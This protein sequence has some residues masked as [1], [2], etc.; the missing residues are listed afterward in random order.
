MINYIDNNVI[1]EIYIAN[2]D[3]NY[4]NLIDLYLNEDKD[5]IANQYKNSNIML[6]IS[7]YDKNY[8]NFVL[9][10]IYIN[11]QYK[12]VLIK[13]GSNYFTDFI[14][15][16]NQKYL[17]SFFIDRTFLAFNEYEIENDN[18]IIKSIEPLG[19][20]YRI[21][22]DYLNNSMSIKRLNKELDIYNKYNQINYTNRIIKIK[23]S[24]IDNKGFCLEDTTYDFSQ[25]SNITQPIRE[26]YNYKKKLFPYHEYNNVKNYIS[27]KDGANLEISEKTVKRF[28]R[29]SQSLD[30]HH[31]TFRT[32]LPGMGIY[33]INEEISQNKLVGNLDNMSSYSLPD[34][35]TYSPNY[36]YGKYKYTSKFIGYVLNTS[37]D[38]ID[39]LNSSYRINSENFSN[40]YSEETIYSEYFLYVLLDPSITTQAG[41]DEI[42]DELN[43]DHVN[44]VFDGTANKVYSEKEPLID[45]GITNEGNIY[46]V[47]HDGIDNS[48]NYILKTGQRSQGGNT[49]AVNPKNIYGTYGYV[50]TNSVT[51]LFDNETF[52]T[53]LG[54]EYYEEGSNYF[55]LYEDTDD[56]QYINYNTSQYYRNN[57]KY[58]DLLQ[59][60]LL[61]C[62]VIEK[63]VL[64]NTIEGY[65][66]LNRIACA[67]QVERPVFLK[68]NNVY[69][70]NEQ[71]YQK[72]FSNG[73][74]DLYYIEQLKNKCVSKYEPIFD[75]KSYRKL[76][77]KNF[78]IEN[79]INLN[80]RVNNEVEVNDHSLNINVNNDYNNISNNLDILENE[81]IYG[82]KPTYTFEENSDL[83]FID[84]NTNSFKYSQGNRFDIFNGSDKETSISQ[85]IGIK[86]IPVKILSGNILSKLNFNDENSYFDSFNEHLENVCL[87][88]IDYNQV[89]SFNNNISIGKY[90]TPIYSIVGNKSEMYNKS[91]I[92][93]NST[94]TDQIYNEIPEV[95]E[96]GNLYDSEEGVEKGYLICNYNVSILSQDVNRE[97]I[98]NG[99]SLELKLN[100][101]TL[102]PIFND[103]VVILSG[104]SQDYFGN[105]PFDQPNNTELAIIEKAQV[106]NS[107]ITY[108]IVLPDY[109]NNQVVY[110]SF[111]K[112]FYEKT[113][114]ITFKNKFQK[115][116]NVSLSGDKYY[117][118]YP[119][120]SIYQEIYHDNL[121][122]YKVRINKS[123]IIHIENIKKGDIIILDYG[124]KRKIEIS[125]NRKPPYNI[126]ENY[127]EVPTTY[128]C[129]IK[130]IPVIFDDF[131]EFNIENPPILYPNNTKILHLKNILIDNNLHPLGF[132]DTLPYNNIST[133]PFIHNGEWFTKIYF[134]SPEVKNGKFMNGL[135]KEKYIFNSIDTTSFKNKY[136]N[137]ILSID[138]FIH[139][140]KG[141]KIPFVDLNIQDNLQLQNKYDTEIFL[142]PCANNYYQTH[143]IISNDY[144]YRNIN[145]DTIGFKGKF[146]KDLFTQNDGQEL[147][148]LYKD[149]EDNNYNLNYFIVKGIFFGFGGILEERF[150]KKSIQNIINNEKTNR[151]SRIK[152]SN[153]KFFVFLDLDTNKSPLVFDTNIQK[154]KNITNQSG[155]ASVLPYDTLMTLIEENLADTSTDYQNKLVRY[156][157]G[158]KLCKKYI[159]YPYNLNPNN[160]VYLVIPPFNN[161]TIAENNK[162]SSA[163]AKILLPG[164]SNKTL[165]NTFVAANKTFTEN[166]FNNLTELEIS[167]ITNEGFLFDFNGSEHSFAIEI[168]EIIDKFEYINPRFGNI[169]F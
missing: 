55:D 77:S 104:Y 22:Q 78:I 140:M 142:E 46:E 167:F 98:L 29:V 168:T 8:C 76:N 97:F 71:E 160:Y 110:S 99:T 125:E 148:W 166:L 120:L 164:E 73:S 25:T 7:D 11:N 95:I 126:N 121:N 14:I 5:D 150:A 54:Q 87:L 88:D 45:P 56:S 24:P 156:G 92:K 61:G 47:E 59:N 145:E 36:I 113:I 89:K 134:N 43:K 68:K 72:L 152:S 109:L 40:S 106:F 129:E 159:Q 64:N 94:N 114:L 115:E 70:N 81:I 34:T 53:H 63:P 27:K 128:F 130:S 84:S 75:E 154:F 13:P 18:Q 10:R 143:D 100:N 66:Y 158:G 162:L 105:E 117:I 33:T 91:S 163:F 139:S 107:N 51:R 4:F 93:D 20:F 146:V 161:I 102:L 111:T 169:E 157:Y 123:N 122:Q 79:H 48:N 62:I 90:K 138:I 149:Y 42:F 135:G 144:S 32:F 103:M 21:I 39:E 67:T 137:K 31:H 85:E 3:N 131:I 119:C 147:K 30:N 38:N 65:S 9:K 1:S 58:V 15:N 26:V 80:N 82:I 96:I 37:I 132:N 60:A 136:Y 74:L 101:E 2:L 108:D 41:I 127:E 133:Q 83:V 12:V 49:T 50:D 118:T 141:L 28:Q 16:N 23:V 165:F 19:I 17:I 69:S 44:Y 153:N 86:D 124:N 57:Y 52:N 112:Q 155:K 6:K 35:F 151:V 116:H